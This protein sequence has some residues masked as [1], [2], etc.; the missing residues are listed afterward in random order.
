[1]LFEYC[2][3]EDDTIVTH[4]EERPDGTV[5]VLVERPR[6]WGFDSAECE[7]PSLRWSEID[8]FSDD[9]FKRLQRFVRNNALLIMRLARER[10]PVHA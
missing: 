4:S 8:G 9:G 10:T 5:R 2:R 7:L 3:L 6:D 1:M